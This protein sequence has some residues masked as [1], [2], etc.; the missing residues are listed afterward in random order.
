MTRED[1]AYLLF[2][3]IAAVVTGILAR[4]R[5]RSGYNWFCLTCLISPLFSLPLLFAL[6][7][8]RPMLELLEIA[9]KVY[10]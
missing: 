3:V 2:V 10:R 7:N 8:R 6:K 1:L 5:G 9:E 4:R